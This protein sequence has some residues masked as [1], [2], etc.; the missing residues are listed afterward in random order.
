MYIPKD[1]ED[2]LK[3]STIRSLSL[4]GSGGISLELKS[5]QDSYIIYIRMPVSVS[6]R[7]F[8][9][10]QILEI[11]QDGQK[12]TFHFSHGEEICLDMSAWADVRPAPAFIS[13]CDGRV[14]YYNDWM[15]G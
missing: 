5:E 8:I 6:Y 3:T 11:L 2:K 1:L 4:F 7:D 10:Q 15:G 14:I 9:G 13:Y 12:I